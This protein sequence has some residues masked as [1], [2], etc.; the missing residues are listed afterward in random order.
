MLLHSALVLVVVVLVNLG[1]VANA[2][3]P[4]SYDLNNATLAVV[5]DPHFHR[6]D[7]ANLLDQLRAFL[8][9]G[10]LELLQH[11]GLNVEYYG[12]ADYALRSDLTAV[13]SVATCADTWAIYR[14]MEQETLLQ[15]AITDA[16]C[17]R[18][19]SDVGLTI[20]L[21]ESGGVLPQM[22][23]DMKMARALTW[24]SAIVLHD[25]SI[26]PYLLDRLLAALAVSTPDT[27][28]SSV[29]AYSLPV[30]HSDW[31]RRKRVE[32]VLR[33]L[34][35][36]RLTRL[37]ERYL[38][39]VGS[40]LVGVI[41]DVAKSLGMVH[42][43]SQWL[44]VL[45]D[46]TFGNLVTLT[47]LLHEGDNVAFVANYTS[48]APQETCDAGVQCHARE[49]LRAFLVALDRSVRDE[50]ELATQVSDEEWEAIRPAREDRMA[51][52]LSHVRDLLRTTGSC[53][54]CT[55]WRL[56]SADTWGLSHSEPRSRPHITASLVDVG[57]W[58]P[59]EGLTLEDHIFPH[60]AHGFKGRTL[61]LVSFH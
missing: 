33:S 22:I 48:S 32:G 39:L 23:L 51:L 2:A 40:D 56:R 60:A 25:N 10:T 12:I 19:P 50:Q 24:R 46:A 37:G 49:L 59:R 58:R 34:P 6:Q 28:P 8:G 42:P 26:D 30:E 61:P 36:S 5:V 29:T 35:L 45:S 43:L 3:E 27:L 13:V 55:A 57:W 31:K 47:S 17:P 7:G 1:S 11:G 14:R 15:L 53:G 38:V 18:L 21:T 20:P 41:M 4:P 16:D 52:L 9:V 54:N 44:Y